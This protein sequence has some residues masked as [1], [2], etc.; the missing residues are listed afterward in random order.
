MGGG[1][2]S[3]FVG[4]FD[5]ESGGWLELVSVVPKQKRARKYRVKREGICELRRCRVGL[6]GPGIYGVHSARPLLGKI[7][8]HRGLRVV[9]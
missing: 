7:D 9:G 1:G 3:R 4:I 6:K 8:K 5:L 2:A